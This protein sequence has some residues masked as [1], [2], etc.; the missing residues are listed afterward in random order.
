VDHRTRK[1]SGKLLPLV[2]AAFASSSLAM[3]AKTSETRDGCALCAKPPKPLH[4]PFHGF[5]ILK[6]T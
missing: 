3:A 5:Q 4:L 6:S 2:V 1:P